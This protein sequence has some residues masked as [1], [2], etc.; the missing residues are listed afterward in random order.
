MKLFKWGKTL[1]IVKIKNKS[2]S[3]KHNGNPSV[4]LK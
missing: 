2:G 4:F 1:I 3:K